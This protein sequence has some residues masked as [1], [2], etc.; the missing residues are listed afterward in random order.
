MRTEKLR[1]LFMG[2]PSFAVGV[3]KTIVENGF[4]VVGV[5]TAPDTRKGRG[6]TLQGSAV[7]QYAISEDIPVLQPTNLKNQTFLEALKAFS[8]NLQIVV[9]FR[10]LPKVVWEIPSFGTFNLHASLLPQYRGAAPINWAIINKEKTTGVTTFFIDEKIDTGEIILSKEIGISKTETVGSLH[11]MLMALGSEVVIDTI[12]LIG[13]SATYPVKQPL[14][15][16]YLKLNLKQAPKLTPINTYIK[17]GS[18]ADSI[19]HFV[20]GL[21]PYPGAWSYL[22]Q[23]EDKIKV[24]IFKVSIGK[25][26][27]ENSFV[28]VT[29]TEGQKKSK[30]DPVGSVT[31]DQKKLYVQLTHQALE[32]IEIQLPGKRKMLA[33]DLLNGYNFT[34]DAKMIGNP[35]SH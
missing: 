5:I 10:M 18:S 26:D 22:K 29:N 16:D 2:T 23:G 30:T 20:R 6:R 7:K 34:L 31:V 21:N 15:D 19:D 32:I 33:K 9:A 17:W 4:N 12:K 24:K 1:I 35:H 8:A 25:P 28:S 11:D 14:G 3:L 13:N 27:Q